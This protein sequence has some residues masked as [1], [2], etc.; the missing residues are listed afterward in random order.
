ML[1]R[2]SSARTRSS[3]QPVRSVRGKDDLGAARREGA[4]PA[5]RRLPAGEH[6]DRAAIE[7]LE[8]PG[9]VREAQAG[10]EDRPQHLLPRPMGVADG[11]ARVVGDERA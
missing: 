5:G 3:V 10:V 11:E 4:G 2:P 8:Q 6:E 9:S 1:R 7:R